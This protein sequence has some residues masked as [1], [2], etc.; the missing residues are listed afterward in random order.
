MDSIS[1]NINYYVYLPILSKIVQHSIIIYGKRL[2]E[3]VINKKRKEKDN[4]FLI[5][6]SFCQNK[7]LHYSA[8]YAQ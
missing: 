4:C 2:P 3:I 5:Y 1:T 8:E 7:P 6:I